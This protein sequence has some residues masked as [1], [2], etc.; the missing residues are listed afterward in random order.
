M[1]T[2]KLLIA[3][4]SRNEA[5]T[6]WIR[7]NNAADSGI[8]LLFIDDLLNEYEISDELNDSQAI[9]RWYKSNSLSYSNE[10]HCLLN[11]ITYLDDALFESYQP[12]DREY[13]KREFEAYL[14]FALNSFQSPQNIAINGLCERIQSLPQQWSLVHTHLN[15]N[16]PEYY[17]GNK[18]SKPF[19]R[20]SNLVHSSIYNFLNW[21]LDHDETEDQTGLY[22]KKPTGNPLFILSIGSSHLITKDFELND[23][24]REQIEDL[25]HKLRTLFGY[26]IFELLVF[27]TD[28][29]LTFGCMNIDVLRS[30]QDPEFDAFLK[31]N[32][33]RECY[34]C[35]N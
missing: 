6:Q 8:D 29:Q 25:L 24:E 27:I 22:F 31:A 35:L 1:P 5:I 13:A 28:K 21:S 19:G 16:V 18:N 23:K 30:P 3:S 14:G 10:T 32:L 11:R 12:E 15:I 26:F 34:Q 4:Y 17:W 20:E 33:I 7:K 9:I 2:K